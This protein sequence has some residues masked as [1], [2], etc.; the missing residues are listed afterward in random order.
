MVVYPESLE[1]TWN[2]GFCCGTAR[3]AANDVDDLGFLTR[4]LDEVGSAHPIDVTRVYAVE[5]SNGAIM[6]YRLGC[7][8]AER[9]AGVA[10]VGGAMVMDGC[11]PQRPVSVLAIHG[12]EDGHVPYGGGP[13]SGAPDLVP[14]QP[15]VLAAWAQRN[16]C[17][18]T[19]D[20]A[21]DGLVDTAT[22]DGCDEGA[23]VRLL[24]VHGGGH[25]WFAE[26]FD[27]PAGAVDATQV[28]T[29]YFALDSR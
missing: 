10:S 17:E 1:E 15:E 9:L 11:A 4:V 28:I 5:A 18:A 6:A 22:W 3:T 25:T 7:E 2:G 14:S 13:T 16:D 26:E 23:S 19:P 8:R 12:T 27:G 24:T 21:T 29:R 20:W